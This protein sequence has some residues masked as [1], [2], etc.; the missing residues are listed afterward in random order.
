MSAG[1]EWV[2]EWLIGLSTPASI[3][4][5]REHQQ[6]DCAHPPAQAAK[7]REPEQRDNANHDEDR[8]QDA[9]DAHPVQ[10]DEHEV[11]P[12]HHGEGS[13]EEQGRFVRSESDRYQ[14]P[15]GHGE[16]NLH[17]QRRCG[18]PLRER[19]R[20]AHELQDQR[21]HRKDEHPTE[22]QHSHG[23][24]GGPPLEDGGRDEPEEGRY[25]RAGEASSVD[26]ADV[27][28]CLLDLNGLFSH[29]RSDREPWH[30]EMRR[31]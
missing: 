12:T 25:Q 15:S 10:G 30:V 17:R 29:G 7:A 21:R 16:G 28:L 5:E 24:A 3:Q 1:L 13:G 8:G 19:G 4:R 11:V 6:D 22:E 26:R 9:V 14:Q 18:M 27:G 20:T 2:T 31:W 23:R